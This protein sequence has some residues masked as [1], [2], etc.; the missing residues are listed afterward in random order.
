MSELSQKIAIFLKAVKEGFKEVVAGAIGFGI[1]KNIQQSMNPPQHIRMSVVGSSIDDCLRQ[2]EKKACLPEG[3][4]SVKGE[5]M[6]VV[7]WPLPKKG[8]VHNVVSK[9]SKVWQETNSGYIAGGVFEAVNQCMYSEAERKR[10]TPLLNTAVRMADQYDFHAR[11]HISKNC[12]GAYYKGV[13]T[14]CGNLA[15]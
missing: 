6:E 9:T 15:R 3:D 1:V 4:L 10:M 13:C 7:T 11:I 12:P 2:L 5:P 8:V 14:N